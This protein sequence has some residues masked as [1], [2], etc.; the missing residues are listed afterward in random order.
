MVQG[1]C[2]FCF[3][4]SSL[5]HQGAKSPMLSTLH[6]SHHP[7]YLTLTKPTKHIKKDYHV[8]LG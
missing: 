3:M 4:L 5:I 1:T 2:A 8:D 6:A 7:P